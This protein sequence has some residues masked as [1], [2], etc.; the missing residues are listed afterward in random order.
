MC[1]SRVFRSDGTRSR[2]PPRSS[3]SSSTRRPTAKSGRTCW[4][5]RPRSPFPKASCLPVLN[6]RL[7][8][9]PWRRMETGHSPKR[10]SRQPIE[11]SSE[12]NAMTST[13]LRNVLMQCTSVLMFATF[14]AAAVCSTSGAYA[15]GETKPS[16][17]A[18]KPPGGQDQPGAGNP[19]CA[20][21]ASRQSDRCHD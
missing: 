17:V 3:W 19:G 7:R 12:G 20:S 6:T 16:P 5:L 9:G 21:G 14:V 11:S 2:T 15:A 4:P 13:R 1:L 18:A 8:S 10:H